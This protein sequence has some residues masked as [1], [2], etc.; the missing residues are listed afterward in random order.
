MEKIK[1][2]DEYSL[3]VERVDRQHRHMFEIINKI[4]EQPVLPGDAEIVADTIK[5]MVCYARRHFA[6]EEKMMRQYGYP[7]LES[8]K[9][10]H[11]YFIDTTAELAV[12]F[13]NNKNTT[14]GEIAEFLSIWLTNHIL[15]TDMK[16]KELLLKK[17]PAGVK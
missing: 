14:G 7:D 8:H 15:K 3:G 17:M 9:K 16:Y 5:E 2:K 1:W 12:N 11:N 4:I 10:Q 6:D 13:M